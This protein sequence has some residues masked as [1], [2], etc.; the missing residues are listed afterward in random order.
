MIGLVNNIISNLHQMVMLGYYSEWFAHGF[1]RLAYPENRQ[2]ER[3]F[4]T[5]DL[6]K[7]PGPSKGYRDLRGF[8]IKKIKN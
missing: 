6:V 1:T 4:L 2:I 8:L 7:Y 5:W 3:P